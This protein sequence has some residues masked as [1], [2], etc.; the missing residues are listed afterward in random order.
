MCVACRERDASLKTDKYKKK[1][2]ALIFHLFT[3]ENTESLGPLCAL[4][5]RASESM[6]HKLQK[7]LD[8]RGGRGCSAL[9]LILHTPVGK[10][11]CHSSVMTVSKG[12]QLSYRFI[13][14]E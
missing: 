4:V 2:Q 9:S 7:D 6:N 11:K 10:P 13:T 8:L 1:P 14:K 3:S 5:L 12:S